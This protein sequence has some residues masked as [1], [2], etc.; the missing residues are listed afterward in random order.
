M[1]GEAVFLAPKSER[2]YLLD[3]LAL[4]R[5]HAGHTGR[6]DI[7]QEIVDPGPRSRNGKN[8]YGKDFFAFVKLVKMSTPH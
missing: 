6:I 8:R 5:R 7:H 1:I 3:Y 4:A 2:L